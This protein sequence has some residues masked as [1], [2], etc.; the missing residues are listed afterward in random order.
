MEKLGK[1]KEMEEKEEMRE[2]EKLARG[3]ASCEGGRE[4][5]SSDATVMF[6]D[7]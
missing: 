6:M 7:D 1:R 3:Q 5:A 2:R 4:V